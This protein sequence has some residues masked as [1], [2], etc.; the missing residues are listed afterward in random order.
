M[1]A[2]TGLC[3]VTGFVNWWARRLMV[4]GNQSACRNKNSAALEDI[5]FNSL[6]Q[7][8]ACR[9]FG[10]K[11][12]SEPVMIYW[13]LD[14][15]ELTSMKF[16]SKYKRNL[17]KENVFGNVVCKMAAILSQPL[18]V[19]AIL[20]EQT[21][22]LLAEGIFKAMRGVNSCVIIQFYWILFS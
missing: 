22:R 6:D 1:G 9:L 14:H 20:S 11:P 5:P 8:I 18:C 21:Q 12:L 17:I 3:H 7:L 13:P 4:N 16:G 15:W 10:G 2:E 19:D